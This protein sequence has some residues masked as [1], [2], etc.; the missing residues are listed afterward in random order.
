VL[1][2]E[3]ALMAEAGEQH[4]QAARNKV[5]V[6]RR[7]SRI[8]LGLAIIGF[9]ASIAFW[10]EANTALRIPESVQ[11]PFI[12]VLTL[13]PMLASATGLSVFTSVKNEANKRDIRRVC[14]IAILLCVASAAT[15]CLALLSLVG[16]AFEF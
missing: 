13:F 11:G 2:C 6:Q 7:L 9:L 8:A 16:Q 3:E 15:F 10:G 4:N 14:S 1:F 5:Q 12:V